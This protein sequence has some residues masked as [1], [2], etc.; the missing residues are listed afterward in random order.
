M[1]QRAQ[2][3][4]AALVQLLDERGLLPPPWRQVWA[5]LPRPHFIPQEI[6]RQGPERCEPVTAYDDW[7]DLVSSDEPVIIQVD[8]GREDGPGVAT[9]SNSMPSMVAK[10]LSLLRVGNHDRV[11]EI[12]TASGH[13]AALLAERLGDRN[14]YS[15]EIDPLLAAMAAHHLRPLGYTPN[16]R[17][18]DGEQGWPEEAPFDRIVSTCSLR[19]VP[20][21]F[22][23]QVRPGG[24]IVAPLYRD[25]WSGALVQ[26]TVQAD[27]RAWGHFHGGASY[28]PMR[29]QRAAAPAVEVDSSTA[30]SRAAGLDPEELLSL[31]FALYAGARLPG[32]WMRH[33]RSGGAV[34]VWAGGGDGSATSTATGEDVWQ[35]GPRDLWTEIEA[36][37]RAYVS[38]GSPDA[39][40]F[41]LTVTADG[42]HVW[43]HHPDA[44]VAPSGPAPCN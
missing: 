2:E 9:S 1:P 5:K 31:G 38:V 22:V 30:R 19:Q 44:I 25:F 32:V 3:G 4:H 20:Y 29:S 34:H 8:D 10:M 33:S 15:V 41:G 17:L 13:V 6:W 14:V 27:G 43:M 36:V 40:S 39:Q 24:I 26:L 21:A 23:E 11:L 12:G 7:C 42:Q 16:L 35:Y 37:H 28:M 18:G